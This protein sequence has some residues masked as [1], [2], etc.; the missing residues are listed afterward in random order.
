MSS[1]TYMHDKRFQNHNNNAAQA[2][3]SALRLV[4]GGEHESH[5]SSNTT[6][7]AV[8]NEVMQAAAPFN[9]PAL[10]PSLKPKNPLRLVDTPPNTTTQKRRHA[11]SKRKDA[12]TRDVIRE[13]RKASMNQA[14]SA[15][16]PRW[17]L[18][19]KTRQELQGPAINPDKRAKLLSLAT[20]LGIRAFDANLV[21]AIVQD[22]ARRGELP[23]SVTAPAPKLLDRLTIIP[24]VK[25]Q[26]HNQSWIWMAITVVTTIA[27]AAIIFL[28]LVRTFLAG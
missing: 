28:A 7:A 18:A 2:H 20:K 1:Q 22:E 17:V 12:A 15:D 3:K 4:T 6:R 8:A 23:L 24:P 14:V 19:T 21:I 25:K 16:D 5:I 10:S 13:M 27:L 9:F 11:Q 26:P